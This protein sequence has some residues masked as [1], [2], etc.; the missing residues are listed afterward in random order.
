MEFEALSGCV[1][2][3]AIEVHRQLGPGLLESVY[4]MCLAHELTAA[5]VECETEKAIAVHYKGIDLPCGF[6]M[7]MLVEHALVI[8]IK[9]VD[10]LM[11]I[12]ET[13]LL[14]YLKLSGIKTGLLINFNSRAIRNGIR[15]LVL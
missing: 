8:E 12:H 2:G 7:D 13:Q 10:V 1:I 4:R 9:A 5:G 6:R 11:P 3:C 14:T 15:R